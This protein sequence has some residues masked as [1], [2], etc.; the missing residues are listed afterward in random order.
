MAE[1]IEKEV[2]PERSTCQ[3]SKQQHGKQP[4]ESG[5]LYVAGHIRIYDPET[6]QVFVSQRD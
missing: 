2:Q 4:D 6:N 3:V 1:K 5:N